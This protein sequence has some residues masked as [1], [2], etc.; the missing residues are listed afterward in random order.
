M[1]LFIGIDTEPPDASPAPEHLTLRFLGERAPDEAE[2]IGDALAAAV[3]PV[4]PFDL[5][6]GGIG[7]FPSPAR[8]RVV[9]IGVTDGAAQVRELSARIDDALERL[10]IPRDA[11]PFVPHVT[12]FRVRDARDSARARSALDGRTDP[13]PARTIRVSAVELKESTLLAT[14]PRHRTIARCPLEGDGAPVT[15]RRTPGR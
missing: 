1:R 15:P 4:A 6:L 14:G 3:R 5:T 8:P 2:R 10:G 11:P 7:A 12:W 13:P 9:W